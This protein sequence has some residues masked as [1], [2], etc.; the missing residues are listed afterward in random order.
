MPEPEV[1]QGERHPPG[2][3]GEASCQKV[4]TSQGQIPLTRSGDSV[5]PFG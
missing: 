1:T 3:T 5:P 2:V 4:V